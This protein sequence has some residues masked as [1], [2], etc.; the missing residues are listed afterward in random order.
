MKII[1]QVTNPADVIGRVTVT[2]CNGREYAYFFSVNPCIRYGITKG[3]LALDTTWNPG[4][5]LISGQTPAWA[6]VDLNDWVV[7]QTNGL[8]ASTPLSV[9]AI[10]QG[11]ASKQ[12]M[13]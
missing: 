7:G 10:N 6:L 13:I 2:D 9:F 1:D 5:L 8:P 3:H 4:P 12:F 11:N